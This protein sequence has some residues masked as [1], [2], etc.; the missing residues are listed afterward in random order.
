M[1]KEIEDN[2]IGCSSDFGNCLGH[3]CP[4]SKHV[5]W[6]CDHCDDYLE[7]GNSYYVDGEYLCEY[8][9]KKRFY[10]E[11]DWSDENE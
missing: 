11:L 8:C 9:L 4:N 10:I 3:C 1:A 7:D 6:K 2:C 5:V